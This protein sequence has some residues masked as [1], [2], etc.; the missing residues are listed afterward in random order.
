[1][2]NWSTCKLVPPTHPE[3]PDFS[4]CFLYISIQLLLV[5]L[6]VVEFLFQSVVFIEIQLIS[7]FSLWLST[8]LKKYT[9][10]NNFDGW[11]RSDWP[12]GSFVM[13]YALV[14]LSNLFQCQVNKYS[15]KNH[16]RN[17][18]VN[19]FKLIHRGK[20]GVKSGFCNCIFEWF[21]WSFQCK[22]VKG[23]KFILNYL[24]SFVLK[25]ASFDTI[26]LIFRNLNSFYCST[27]LLLTWTEW[28]G[29]IPISAPHQGIHR[30]SYHFITWH[31][32]LNVLID[33]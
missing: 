17:I 19:E 2:R 29:L 8:G 21:S 22:I 32:W 4:C 13:T 28:I 24:L 25:K 16:F 6:G 11:Q 12:K 27:A 26:S 3:F 7:G 1:M 33:K 15:W 30:V 5:K 14:A 31:A 9:Y 10:L 18:F 23:L 20:V